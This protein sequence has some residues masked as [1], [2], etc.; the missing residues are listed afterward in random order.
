MFRVKLRLR[1]Y[2]YSLQR[3]RL[4]DTPFLLGT[5]AFSGCYGY[6]NRANISAR[7]S[8]TPSSL[9]TNM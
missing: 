7:S 9:C 5:L 8:D 3:K 6:F 4:A 2:M 1:K